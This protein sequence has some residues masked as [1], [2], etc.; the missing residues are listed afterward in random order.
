[1]NLNMLMLQPV[2]SALDST[3]S[4]T[5]NSRKILTAFG[6]FVRVARSS[7]GAAHGS[8]VHTPIP[9]PAPTSPNFAYHEQYKLHS[10]N[11]NQ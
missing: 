6:P 7:D 1:M 3:S 9:T 10:Q 8:E 11:E 5:P 2:S 4:R